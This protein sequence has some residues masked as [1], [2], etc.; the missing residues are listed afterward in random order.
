MSQLEIITNS[1]DRIQRNKQTQI[2]EIELILNDI[3]F[4]IECSERDELDEERERDSVHYNQQ[5]VQLGTL[6]QFNVNGNYY[7]N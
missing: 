1:H 2:I 6:R 3:V 5:R 4:R 7:Y